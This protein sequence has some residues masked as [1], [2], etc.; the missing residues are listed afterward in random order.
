MN[1]LNERFFKSVGRHFLTLTCVQTTPSTS[2]EKT[3]VFSGFLVIAGGVWFYVTAGHILK[4]IRL[5]L[6]AGA[7]FDIWRL[8]DQTA[9]NQFKNA[10][11]PFAFDI[12]H[13][14]VIED[15]Y[16]GLDYA[17]VPLGEIYCRQLQAGG[18][19]P[20]DKIAWGN[21]LTE[22]DQ[23][24]LVGVPSETVSYDRKTIITARVVVAPIKPADKP[25]S[26]G[27][28]AQNQFYGQLMDDSA[29]IVGDIDGMSGS[30]V[31]AIK[32][33]EDTW[34]YTVI[35]VQS[36]W[37]AESRVIAA[38]PFSSFA[39]ALEKLVADCQATLEGLNRHATKQL[40][41]QE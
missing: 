32:K 36:S 33:I 29:G 27:S 14:A 30:P 39:L 16:V 26:A 13:W 4:D 20:I 18:A 22:H 11:V 2:G 6:N 28:K 23:W 19:I 21:H 5:A 8:G 38:C 37:Y 3:L 17:A 31:F 9:G 40:H 24:A 41:P 15:E 34:K 10:G 7:K 25:A 1:S 35:G 12:N